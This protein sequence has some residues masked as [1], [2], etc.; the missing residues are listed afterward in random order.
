MNHIKNFNNVITLVPQVLRL[1]Y[2][3]FKA[4]KSNGIDAKEAK[5]IVED[6]FTIVIFAIEEFDLQLEQEDDAQEAEDASEDLDEEEEW[7]NIEDQ[8]E[9]IIGPVAA[10]ARERIFKKPARKK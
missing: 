8:H 10:A 9:E 7:S 1:A 4:W 2:K 5:E 3:I 6:I